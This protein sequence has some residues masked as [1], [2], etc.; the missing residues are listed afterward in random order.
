[1][2]ANLGGI[3]FEGLKG[4]STFTDSRATVY[5]EIGMVNRKPRLQRTGEALQEISFDI[6]LHADFSNVEEDI[7][8]FEDIREAGNSV[9]LVL[10]NGAVL[11]DFLLTAITK[12]I[13]KT[14]PLGNIIYLTASITLKEYPQGNR[15]E[16]LAITA[17]E[18]GFASSIEKVVPSKVVAITP[19]AGVE[20]GTIGTSIN[21]DSKFIQKNTEIAEKNASRRPAIF[22]LISEKTDA[23][24]I[25]CTDLSNKMR[26]IQAEVNNATQIIEN[27][28][29]VIS[30]A[31]NVQAAI[32][33]ADIDALVAS[34]TTFQQANATL[35]AS[36]SSV[37]VLIASRKI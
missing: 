1:M 22:P 5:A 33:G 6:L 17:V 28:E 24:S 36:M 16:A 18:Q 35:Q 14:D 4:F 8:Q 29:A 20:A 25:A 3:T 31:S 34:N 19:S 32:S 13:K 21:I 2:Y 9:S 15:A 7:Q 10:G 11:G 37:I 30:F 12:N 23:I 26:E 27:A